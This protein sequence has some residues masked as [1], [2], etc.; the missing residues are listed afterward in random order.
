MG[1][2]SFVEDPL[3]NE[4]VKQLKDLADELSSGEGR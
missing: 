4:R 3:G 2:K 1:R